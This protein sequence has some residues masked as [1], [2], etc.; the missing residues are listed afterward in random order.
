[1]I[2]LATLLLLLATFREAIALDPNLRLAQYGHK[3]WRSYDGYFNGEPSA[4]AQTSDGYIWVGT[5]SGLLRFDGVR[6]VPWNVISGIK[7]P[8]ETVTAL[9][10][11]RD[12]SLW[13]GTQEGLVHSIGNSIVAVPPETSP[14]IGLY[15][16]PS[17]AIWFTQAPLPPATG[18][19]CQVV[20]RSSRCY[21]RPDGAPPTDGTSITGSLDGSVFVGTSVGVLRWK[22]GS[23]DEIGPSGIDQYLGGV[24]AVLA[25]PD[26]GLW[27]GLPRGAPK[28]SLQQFAGEKWKPNSNAQFNSSMQSITALHL[29]DGGALW[30]GTANDGIYRIHGDTLD[31]FRNEDGLS[32]K[33]VKR[34]MKDREGMVWAVT[35]GGLDS[36]R[37]V[38]ITTFTTREGSGLSEMDSVLAG[39]DGRLWIGG[40]GSLDSLQAGL[41]R[42]LRPADGLP[43]TQVTALFEDRKGGLWIGVE[44]GLFLYRNGKFHPVRTHDGNSTGL[45]VDITEDVDGVIWAEVSASPRKLLR[46]DG[47]KVTAEYPAPEMP[48]ARRIAADPGGGLWLGLMDGNIARLHEGKLEKFI[49]RPNSK[50]SFENEI[51]HIH[52]DEEG[53]VLAASAA[54]LIGWKAGTQRTLTSRN[55][56]P[57]DSIQG[58]LTDDEGNLWLYTQCGLVEIPKHQLTSWW[59]T[60]DSPVVPRVLDSLDGAK[61]GRMPPFVSAAKTADG[62]LWFVNGSA[63]QMVDPAKLQ[64]NRVPPP[65]HIES[66]IADRKPYSPVDT[67]RLPERTRDIEIDYVGLS[68]VAPQKVRF[69]YRLQGH[70]TLWQE[71]GGRR[72]ALY[73]DLEPGNYSFQVI[74]ANNDGLWN[75]TGDT[76][77]FS[78]APAWHQTLAFRLLCIASGVALLWMIHRV[79]M[80]QVAKTLSARFDERMSERTRLARE[81][82]DTLLQTVQGS[83]LIVDS[84]L[85][86]A[87]EPS[88]HREKLERLSMWLESA[89]SEGRAALSSLR[90]STT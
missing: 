55:G 33:M 30:L 77:H 87:A 28:N 79:R 16:D 18:T 43:G 78:V 60:P 64:T 90:S 84:A 69:R 2:R 89:I 85:A 61:P 76:L 50:V 36:F 15:E 58:F 29:E 41:F 32:G 68:F 63:L 20:G 24:L 37:D 48:E 44:R 56:L 72:Q 73:N 11:A 66:V 38:P 34:F 88:Q 80:W 21:G 25:T 52:V 13:I 51:E 40:D 35:S 23:L 86:T 42:S 57:C 71:P 4:I 10:G 14:V 82:H 81:F 67:L 49:Y 65:V 39:R 53:T 3:S 12:G 45:V 59:Q 6:F 17:G 7:L 19:L 27:A 26:G 8:S 1:M 47:L 9:L 22:A 46:V 54:G 62:R 75:E 31:Q 5:P 74:A 70:E 83:K